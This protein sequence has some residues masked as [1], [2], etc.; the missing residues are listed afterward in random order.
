MYKRQVEDRRNEDRF[1]FIDWTKQAF[2]NI[3]VV[4]PGNGI[5]QQINLER[6][7]PV[8]YTQDGV[9]FPLSLIHI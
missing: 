8:I 2:R 3:E 4:P 7:S 6:M 1:H 9:A 5:M